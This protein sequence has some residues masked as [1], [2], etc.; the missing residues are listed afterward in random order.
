MVKWKCFFR[1][2]RNP[3]HKYNVLVKF[4]M[5]VFHFQLHS[6]CDIGTSKNVRLRRAFVMVYNELI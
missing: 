2:E 4:N 5:P 6:D 1:F 3:E